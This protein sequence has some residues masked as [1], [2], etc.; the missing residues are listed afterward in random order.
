MIALI[1]YQ[2]ITYLKSYRYIPPLALYLISL[3]VTYTYAPNPIIDSFYNTAIYLFLLS[4]WF[5]ISF[6]HAEDEKQERI[7]RIHVTKKRTYF[8]SKIVCVII[9]G[10]ILSGVSVLYPTVVGGFETKPTIHQL[11]LGY[12]L[13][14]LFSVMG[15]SISLLFTRNITDSGNA[16]WFGPALILVLTLAVAGVSYPYEGI[17]MLIYVLPPVTA[18]IHFIN[19]G[20]NQ[21]IAFGWGIGYSFLLVLLYIMIV[22]R[23]DL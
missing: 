14:W 12:V 5:T 22:Q 20:M 1:R 15:M 6:F 16:S 17:Q 3:I 23:K 18:I 7:T 21:F 13:H 8:I 4:A 9:I 2:F 11:L 10:T 19:E